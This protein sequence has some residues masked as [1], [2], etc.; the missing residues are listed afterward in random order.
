MQLKIYIPRHPLVTH[1]ANLIQ[2]VDM[3][4][5]FI[6]NSVVELSY[7]MF[8]EAVKD[9][10][11]VINVELNFVEQSNESQLIDPEVNLYAIPIFKSGLLMTE[12]ITKL[13][14]NIKL[15]YISFQLEND[16]HSI[17]SEDLNYFSLIPKKSKFLI[18]DSVV[19]ASDK[20]LSILSAMASKGIDFDTVRIVFILC[21]SNVLQDIA[22][23]YPNL[24][25]YSACVK[26]VQEPDQI[27]PYQKL[28]DHLFI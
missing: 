11:S 10:L 13:L 4:P 18:F 16:F 8:Y 6:K 22:E 27:I 28:Q 2:S 21:T 19:F 26:E 5:N 12:G 14:S 23:Q 20:I 7:W 25:I 3:P 1:L 15:F 24:T 9:W 17:S